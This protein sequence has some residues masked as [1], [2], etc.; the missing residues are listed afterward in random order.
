MSHLTRMCSLQSLA[1]PYKQKVQL[2]IMAWHE[3]K[4]VAFMDVSGNGGTASDGGEDI[5]FSPEL[6]HRG[7]KQ[8]LIG[9]LVRRGVMDAK[10]AA[11]CN[12]QAL[13]RILMMSME[14][15]EKEQELTQKRS[16]APSCAIHSPPCKRAAAGAA[17]EEILS[18]SSVSSLSMLCSVYLN[19]IMF[20]AEFHSLEPQVSTVARCQ[21]RTVG[22]ALGWC[23]TN[24]C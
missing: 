5:S 24:A 14:L 21:K 22:S 15:E 3:S 20:R 1:Y 12:K 18:L 13:Q 2:N 10:C 16:A 6:L 7:T 19:F 11:N 17:E 8:K 9:E 23:V 4:F